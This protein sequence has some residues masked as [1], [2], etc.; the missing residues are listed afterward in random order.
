GDRAPRLARLAGAEV[1]RDLREVLLRLFELRE[2][3]GRHLRRGDLR[4]ERLE[5]RAHHE[6]L[7]QVLPR[8]RAHADAA[9]RDERDEPEGREPAE[10][11]ADRRAR[12]V[13][14]LGELLLAEDG[15]RL[16]LAGDDRLLDHERDVVGLGAVEAHAGEC[17]R[18]DWSS[19]DT[20]KGL[21][22]GCRRTLEA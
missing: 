16:E 4:G 2:I 11:L 5:L 10:R 22:L 14:L 15:A 20:G 17:T 8:D 1:L 12:D 19:R 9:V 6:R 18:L 21:L 7:V 13:E 3:L